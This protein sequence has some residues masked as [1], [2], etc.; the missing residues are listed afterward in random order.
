[1]TATGVAPRTD[2]VVEGAVRP[3]AVVLV[4]AVVFVASGPSF[5]PSD[6]MAMW[7]VLVLTG[8]MAVDARGT[9]AAR[10]APLVLPTILLVTLLWLFA[11]SLWS[12]AP[13]TTISEAGLTASVSAF[14][15]VAAWGADVATLAIGTFAGSAIACWLSLAAGVLTPGTALNQ[16]T[17]YTGALQGIYVHR[18]LLAYAAA[19]GAIALISGAM[20]PWFRRSA[21][22]AGAVG[23]VG[24][25]VGARSATAVVTLIV[26]AGLLIALS[27][28]KGVP[29]TY[30][31]SIVFLV[32]TSLV[33]LSALASSML[34]T[35]TA[36]FGRD[37]TFTGRTLIWAAVIPFIQARPLLGYGWSAVWGDDDVV[38]PL[39]RQAVQFDEATH[40]HDSYLDI[41][42]QVGFVGLALV[43]V[44]L[45]IALR[46]A[47]RYAW[48]A[49]LQRAWPILLI[50]GLTTYSLL[51]SRLNRPLGWML[52]VLVIAA[53]R[54]EVL[55]PTHGH[56]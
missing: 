47:Y 18:N 24:A 44:L 22:L 19:I 1:M 56:R 45:I 39:V 41:A 14:A 21:V 26:C 6:S 25:L 29:A 31:G 50:V 3:S 51:E 23:I 8:A 5:L 12:D 43:L 33:V 34:G 7:I 13:S 38:G 32:V 54:R 16:G 48:T 15:L 28:L 4:A 55:P 40:A 42:L 49:S 46:R 11:S 17:Y 9:A 10:R 35:F 20:R 30:R 2:P 53:T 37:V 36:I 52:V 27:L